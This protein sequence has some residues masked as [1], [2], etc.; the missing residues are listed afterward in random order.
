MAKTQ[1]FR[2]HGRVQGV[3]FRDYTQQ[4][5]T[6]LGLTGWVRNRADGSVEAIATGPA[7]TLEQFQ[8]WL[9]SGSPLAIVDRV[10]TD[11][12]ELTAFDGFEI[13]YAAD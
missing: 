13:R 8:Q 11:Y 10:D 2:I 3:S 4:Q 5:A 9:H 12:C 6:S 7:E 1:Q